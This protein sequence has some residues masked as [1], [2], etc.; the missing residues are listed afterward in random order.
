MLKHAREVRLTA[1]IEAA[2][3]D[4]GLL[5]LAQV[6]KERVENSFEA[7]GVLALAHE[8]PQLP[9][10][11]IPLLLRLR[12]YDLRDTVVRDLRLGRIAVTELPIANRLLLCT[13]GMTGPRVK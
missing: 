6:G 5:L 1:A 8:A 11:H 13:L 12:A 3:P 7:S 2:Y 4:R 10:Q 9:A